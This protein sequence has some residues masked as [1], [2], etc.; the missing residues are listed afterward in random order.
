[1]I[2]SNH[3]GGTS[4]VGISYP[5]LHI[6]LQLEELFK[7][8]LRGHNQLHP[9]AISQLSCIAQPISARTAVTAILL[10]TENYNM[11]S[12]LCNDGTGLYTQVN[13]NS[14]YASELEWHGSNHPI[15]HPGAFSCNQNIVYQSQMLSSYNLSP[16]NGAQHN[17]PM[18]RCSEENAGERAFSSG[19]QED[20]LG[21]PTYL[22][23]DRMPDA[24]FDSALAPSGSTV[25]AT[26]PEIT[27]GTFEYNAIS[28]QFPSDSNSPLAKPF[29]CNGACGKFFW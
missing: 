14:Y 6:V 12:F 9:T 29:P 2:T 18:P 23:D 10:T 4:L 22:W 8:S 24:G 17:E 3:A 5:Y 21:L 16:I 11:S 26:I 1:M 13:P 19:T 7:G 28:N 20:I 27:Q 25:Q 15:N